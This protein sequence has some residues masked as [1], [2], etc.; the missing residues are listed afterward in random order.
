M[1]RIIAIILMAV[2]LLGTVTGCA[3]SEKN[4]PETGETMG[5]T[6]MPKTKMEQLLSTISPEDKDYYQSIGVSP[7]VSP[8]RWC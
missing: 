8:V 3:E 1:K 2:L 6:P 4:S 5:D 7:M